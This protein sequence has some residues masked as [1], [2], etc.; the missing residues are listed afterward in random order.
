MSQVIQNIVLNASLSMPEGGT[1][2]I[3]CENIAFKGTNTLPLSKGGEFVKIAI[4]DSGIGIPANVVEKIF[5]PYF[6]TRQEG[7]GLGLAISQS[8]I[9]KHHGEISVQS[10]VG[11]G[12]TFTL[13]LPASHKSEIQEQECLAESNTSSQ[14]K[15]LTMDDEDIVRTVIQRMLA[16]LGHEVVSA[17][18]GEEAL[19][20]YKEAMKSDR[21]FEITIMDL[22]IPGGMGGKEAVKEIL[23]I[24]PHAKVIVSSGY[25]NDPIMANFKDYGFCAAIVKP[26]QLQDLSQAMSQV[27]E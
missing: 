7:S 12:S 10:T 20:L 15:I 21:P 27:A 5:D 13:Y 25:S 2:K 3:T 18:D 14:M 17:V 22:T 1:I 8:I 26:Y 24:D 11:A 6:S 9:A 16:K 19:V 4:Q 23:K